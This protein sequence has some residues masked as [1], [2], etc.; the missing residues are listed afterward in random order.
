MGFRNLVYPERKSF[1]FEM[2]LGLLLSLFSVVSL[3]QADLLN[4]AQNVVFLKKESQNGV[5]L[6]LK[7]SC[8]LRRVGEG[9]CGF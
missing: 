8:N 6:R 4:Q 9:G 5:W 7:K 3:G 1:I 2:L